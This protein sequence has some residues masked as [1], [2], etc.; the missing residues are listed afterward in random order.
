[1]DKDKE[2]KLPAFLLYANDYLGSTAEMELET[3]GAYGR[4]LCYQWINGGIPKEKHKIAKLLSCNNTVIT[5]IWKELGCKFILSGD[6]LINKR[7]ESERA[8][9]I[10]HR[11]NKSI[12]GKKGMERRWNKDNTAITELLTNPITNDNISTSTS[13]SISKSITNNNNNIKERE[14]KQKIPAIAGTPQAELLQNWQE[15]YQA[16][17]GQPFKA[18]KKDY[19]LATRLLR[20]FSAGAVLEKAKLLFELCNSTKPWFAKSMADFTIGNLSA[21]WN[22]IIEEVKHDGKQCGISDAE[23]ASF[24]QGRE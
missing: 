7:L 13:I 24:M 4:L 6:R 14:L 17:T 1:M 23:L 21:H 12:A 11:E 9:A 2:I 8:K 5:R 22:K 15:L 18:D 20:D 3:Q 10:L 16:K 19:V